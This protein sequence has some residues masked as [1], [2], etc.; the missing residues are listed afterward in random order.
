M[1]FHQ[2]P[3]AQGMYNPELEHD[4]CGIGLY[5]NIK[6][7][8]THDIVKKGLEMLCRLDHRAGKGS[9]GQTGDGAGLMV[10]IPDVFFGLFAANGTFQKKDN[11]E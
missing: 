3:G 9:D 8:P 4:A 11:M 5:A 2:L 10:Q 6:G 1:T 7:L